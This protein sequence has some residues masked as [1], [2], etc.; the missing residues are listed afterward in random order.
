[1]NMAPNSTNNVDDGLLPVTFYVFTLC[2]VNQN[3]QNCAQVSGTTPAPPPAPP[4]ELPVTNVKA[5]RVDV[6]HAAV[7]WSVNAKAAQDFQWLEVQRAKVTF[8]TT[9]ELLGPFQRRFQPL[10]MSATSFDDAGTLPAEVYHYRVCAGTTGSNYLICSEH[11][12]AGP[13]K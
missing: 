11:V 12:Q 6:L 5:V 2:E 10:P 8:T 9:G 7:S 1:M 13:R 3:G 4:I